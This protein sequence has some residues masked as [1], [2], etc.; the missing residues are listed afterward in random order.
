MIRT[1]L[2]FALLVMIYGSGFMFIEIAIEQLTPLEL[3]I[4]RTG[5]GMVLMLS[6]LAYV[7]KPLPR[8]RETWK[9]LVIIGLLNIT[10]PF[11]VI[12]WAQT[13][14]DSGITGV[15]IATNPLFSLVIAHFVFEDERMTRN[16]VI[17]VTLGFIGVIILA[18]RNIE[19]D[20]IDLEGMLGYGGVIFGA[21]CFAAMGVYSR[22]VM[23]RDVESV[24]VSAGATTVAFFALLGIVLVSLLSGVEMT[25]ITDLQPRTLAAVGVLGMFSSFIAFVLGF[26][27]IRQIGATRSSMMAYL[28]PVVSL[29]VGA[30][31]LGEVIDLPIMLGTA[32]ILVGLAFVNLQ[33][34]TMRQLIRSRSANHL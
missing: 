13:L 9:A 16:K 28:I 25:P 29:T 15:L 8:D 18:S 32:V 30:I 21:F 17:G 14:V 5:I 11:V 3:T 12:A 7:H 19:G 1:W 26:Y 31:F 20:T 10:I 24:I 33:P 34:A 2:A 6:L 23:Q 27:V 22:R 4:Y